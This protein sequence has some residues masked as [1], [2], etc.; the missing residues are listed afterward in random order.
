MCFSVLTACSAGFD[1]KVSTCAPSSKR[2]QIETSSDL[3]E[4][5]T[6]LSVLI[7]NVEGLPW[8]ARRNRG[9]SLSQIGIE[10]AKMR[11]SGLGPDVVLLQEVF[12][13]RGR[14]IGLASGYHNRVQGNTANGVA[15]R[16][17]EATAS[18]T[19]KRQFWKGERAG[20]LL[21]AGLYVLSD[22][23]IISA[24]HQAYSRDACAG[25][26]CLAAK[27]VMLVRVH[28]PGVPT[29]VD[30][31]TTHMNSRGRAASVSALRTLAAHKFQT[32]ESASF[33]ND[34]RNPANPLIIG[35]DFNMKR[36]AARFDHFITKKP[37][38]IVRQWCT[39]RAGACDVQMSWDGD[40]PWLDTQDLQAFDDGAVVRLRPQ[41]VE[42]LFDGPDSGGK[43]SDHDGYLVNYR[44]SW[45][46]SE[47]IVRSV[48]VC[49]L[50]GTG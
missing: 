39:E 26:D 27:G 36:S 4:Q 7:Y 12:T 18:H 23:P 24:R 45:P 3:R 33:L 22:Y 42:A 1:D 35:G 29:P 28:V 16:Q 19:A 50:S 49:Q 38:A 25:F 32:I 14:R 20:K 48:P 8:P 41:R 2:P 43:L 15:D 40:A 17:G 9:P 34:T 44:L 10:L 11:S 47:N 31:M 37:Y 30:I 21:G 46:T 13:K 5:S 6:R